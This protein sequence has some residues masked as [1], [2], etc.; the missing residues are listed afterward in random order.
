LIDIPN[1]LENILKALSEW[2]CVFTLC[3][4]VFLSPMNVDLVMG[5]KK[6]VKLVFIHGRGE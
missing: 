6:E 4:F 2:Q 1:G 5:P 3:Y